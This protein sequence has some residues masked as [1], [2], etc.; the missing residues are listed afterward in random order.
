MKTTSYSI[1]GT[2]TA[3]AGRIR[4]GVSSCLLGEPVRYDGGHKRDQRLTEELSEYFEYVPFCPEVAIGLG[5]PRA[6][7]RLQTSAAG[8]RALQPGSEERDVTA[9]LAA[10]ARQVAG[11]AAGISGYIF[12]SRSPSCGMERVKVYDH[13][14]LPSGSAPGIYAAALRES[15]PLLPMEEEGRL[16]DPDLRDNF[17]ERVLVY[18]SW[19]NMEQSGITAAAL[20]AFHSENKFLVMA[21]SQTAM[22]ELGRLVA[23]LKGRIDQ[24]ARIYLERLMPALSKPASRSNQT[25]VL[26]H[27]AGFFSKVLDAGDRRELADAI[28]LYR[29]EQL[30]IIVPLTLIRHHV[31]RYPQPYLAGQ[32]WLE[33]RTPALDTRRR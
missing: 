22:R 13:N 4:I 16:N 11:S 31:R 23:N 9:E 8:V 19:Q 20:I 17:I 27:V 3:A 6:T 24:T 2:D 30:P 32:R 1:S 7:I 21:H 15:L 33:Q 26:Q 25:N 29:R 10:Y 12:K 5:I 28:D 18:R 14:G